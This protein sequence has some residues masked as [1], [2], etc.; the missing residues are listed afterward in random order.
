MNTVRRPLA[1]ARWL[2]VLAGLLGGE[3]ALAQN[4]GYV[5]FLDEYLSGDFYVASLGDVDRSR[6]RSV[7]PRQLRLPRSYSNLELGNGDVSYQGRRFVFGARNTTD[8]D[9]GIYEGRIDVG[10][11]RIR[12]VHPLIQNAGVR[13]EDPRYSW[14]GQQ[15]VYKCNGNICIWPETRP[16]PVVA[17]ACELWAPAF[18]ATGFVVSYVKRCGPTTSDRIFEF[19]LLT[20]QET[21]VPNVGGGPDR[22]AQ[23]LDDGRIVYSHVDLTSAPSNASLWVYDSGTVALLHDRTGSDDDPYPDKHDRNHIAFI[24]WEDGGYHLFVYRRS[25]ANSVRLTRGIGVLGPVLFR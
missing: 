24:G 7:S 2:V 3:A 15:I 20:G 6:P 8:F 1:R 21:E 13:E 10:K 11:R 9:W 17:S 14:D 22:F 4:D 23:F 18:D 12:N 19:N 5:L 16:N 25:R